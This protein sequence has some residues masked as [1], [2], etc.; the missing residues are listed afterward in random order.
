MVAPTLGGLPA[1]AALLPYWLGAAFISCSAPWLDPA[2]AARIPFALLLGADAGADLVHTYHLARTDAAQPLPFAFGGEA[3]AGR[4]RPRDGRRRGAGADGHAR[5]AAAGP[6]D[7]ARTGAARAASRCS[8]TALAARPSARR[9]ARVAVWL[10]LPLLA[11]SG[12]PSMAMAARRRRRRCSCC[13]SRYARCA[14]LTSV[15]RAG[16]ARRRR[17]AARRW[18]RGPGASAARQPVDGAAA[19]R[20]SRLVHV[21]G[22]AAGA[23]DAVALARATCSRRHLVGPARLRG[24]RPARPAIGD[25]RLGPR[26][27]A[28]PAAGWRCW[29]RSRCRP[30]SAAP[31]RRSTGSRCSSSRLCA[32][33]IWVIYVAMQ[34][35]VPAK[36]AAN[37]AKLAP[38]FAP[39]LLAARAGAGRRSA[40]WRGCGWCAGAPGATAHALWKSLVL[41]AGGVA[42]CWLLLMTLWLPL[43][44]YAR[45]YRA[46]VQRIAR[47]CRRSLHRRARHAARQVAALEY[48]GGY[49]VDAATPPVGRRA[50]TTCCSCETRAGRRPPAAAGNWSRANGRTERRRGHRGLP[51]RASRDR[52]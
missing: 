23:V 43:L 5:P 8:C 49:R 36:P 44:D 4:L 25:G 24:R 7:D 46:L 51:A 3:D 10:A 21:A 18:A 52:R 35:G 27:D 45:S 33:T 41:P 20:A 12:A 9:A 47:S 32:S 38:G 15:G 17:V 6:R 31:R 26:A 16:D 2:L 22:L 48:F 29:R 1:D 34:T 28:R 42:L 40:R 39:T 37:V 50:A 11:A 14:P 30:C 13:S 19:S